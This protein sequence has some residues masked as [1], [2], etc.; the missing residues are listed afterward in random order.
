M[1]KLFFAFFLMSVFTFTSFSQP[2][3]E[4][5][6]GEL[7]SLL[8]MAKDARNH[9]A[10]LI[11]FFPHPVDSFEAFGKEKFLAE[12]LLP[13]PANLAL[14]KD[15]LFKRFFKETETS[16]HFKIT[17]NYQ[18]SGEIIDNPTKSFWYPQTFTTKL[19]V[20]IE[21]MP[22]EKKK[23]QEYLVYISTHPRPGYGNTTSIT[24]LCE[25]SIFTNDDGEVVQTKLKTTISEADWKKLLI[26]MKSMLTLYARS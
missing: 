12:W 1:K 13:T 9:N 17:D 20:T 6:A 22:V 3:S 25:G 26:Y 16:V 21:K 7:S 23:V 10:D 8:L 15:S 5:G 19:T 11:N 4:D 18:F 2:V 14:S 24:P